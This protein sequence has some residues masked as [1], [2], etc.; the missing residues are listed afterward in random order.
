[1]QVTPATVNA[2]PLYLEEKTT[3]EIVLGWYP[4]RP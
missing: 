2:F 4:E 3:T 1:M